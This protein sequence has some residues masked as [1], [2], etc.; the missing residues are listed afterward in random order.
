MD[1]LQDRL[2]DLTFAITT[3]TLIIFAVAFVLWLVFRMLK[4]SIARK[5]FF[6]QCNGRAHVVD[7]AYV[8]SEIVHQEQRRDLHASLR[9]SI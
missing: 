6:S 3:Q 7:S 8:S 1:E 9:S 4:V 2:S 5:E